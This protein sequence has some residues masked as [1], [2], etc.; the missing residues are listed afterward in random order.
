MPGRSWATTLTGWL[1]VL[2]ALAATTCAALGLDPY[3]PLGSALTLTGL[4]VLCAAG[5]VAASYRA[6]IGPD[7]ARF[8]LPP[9]GRPGRVLPLLLAGGTVLASAAAILLSFTLS[10]A[11]GREQ[12]RLE[13]AGLDVHRVP[14]ARV[15]S[16]PQATGKKSASR[17][18]LYTTDLA[19]QVPYDNGEVRESVLRGF[20]TTGPPTPGK[21]VDLY[22]AT[23][24]PEIGV[25][26][27]PPGPGALTAVLYTAVGVPTLVLGASLL[28]A[29]DA[30]AVH[31]LRRLR[32][33]VHLPALGILLLG[34][35]L[36][37]PVAVEARSGAF[38]RGA[39]WVAALTPWLALLWVRRASRGAGGTGT[40]R[41]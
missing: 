30:G 31:A 1:M 38:A 7:E 20:T 2:C 41:T 28:K 16:T 18:P 4:T 40:L 39:A 22:Y 29:V 24:H 17:R 32:P 13:R 26:A 27:T 5:W 19:F 35:A 25:R 8:G 12:E 33:R 9:A 36:L 15:L 37:L 23:S 6:R 10:G 14:V 34:L 11:S 3:P 21:E